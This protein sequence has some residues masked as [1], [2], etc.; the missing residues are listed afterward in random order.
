MI[1]RLKDF[2]AG[3]NLP[4]AA[5]REAVASLY[6]RSFRIGT[7]FVTA[8]VNGIVLASVMRN[9]LPLAW[10][11]GA[12]ALCLYRT[13]DW[14]RYRRAPHART[15]A[16]WARRFVFRFFPFGLW[17]GTTAALLFLSDDPLLIA[18][19]VL[20][21]DAQ[22]AG[23]VCSYPGHP[24]AALAF[25]LPSMTMFAIAGAVRGGALGYS[26]AFV[27]IMLMIN[28]LIIIREF[29]RTAIGA[30]VLRDE[31]SALADNLAETHLALQREGAA[32][33][34]FL[35]HMSHEFRTPLNAI[36]GF[37]DVMENEVFGP[38]NNRKYTEYLSDIHSAARHLLNIVNDVLDIAR[39][40]AGEL[41]VVTGPTDPV[42]IAQ[43]AAGLIEQ[44]AQYKRLKLDI[45]IDPKLK[46]TLLQTDEV[47]LKQA[48]I[49]ILSN[50]IKFTNSGGAVRLSA[51]I[52]DNAVFYEIADTG[53]GMSPDDLAKALLPFV[54][55]GS[56][57]LAREGT[58][59][60]LPL[61]R[62]LTEKLGGRFEIVSAEGI[63]TTVTITLPL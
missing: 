45:Q 43:F 14:S 27:E 41:N 46:E 11:V 47:R 18:I 15:S 30:L 4:D 36:M 29:Y 35:A 32:K 2:I 58:G 51:G 33:S 6:P 9:W 5:H 61:S 3:A 10:M 49:N 26:I 52:R 21:T 23:A 56:P 24:P 17:W 57:M 22:S 42:Y 39:I 54:Q 25:V 62:Q 53:V 40:E 34:E 1:R 48:L 13:W 55:V 44:R 8:C 37:S 50:A 63:G 19:A 12:L 7:S 20:A 31:K 28:Y 60:G 59:L 38:I 16:D